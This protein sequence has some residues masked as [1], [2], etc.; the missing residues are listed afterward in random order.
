MG[1]VLVL[2]SLFHDSSGLYFGEYACL[3]HL[4]HLENEPLYNYLNLVSHL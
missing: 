4:L 2:S 3:N 1:E